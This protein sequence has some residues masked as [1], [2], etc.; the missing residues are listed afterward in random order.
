MRAVAASEGKGVV[1][2][3]RGRKATDSLY[4]ARDFRVN[5]HARIQATQLAQAATLKSR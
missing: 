3:A 2:T 5:V 4:A 1:I